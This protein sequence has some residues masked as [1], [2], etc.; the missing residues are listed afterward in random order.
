MILYCLLNEWFHEFAYNLHTILSSFGY[1]DEIFLF[2]SLLGSLQL[3]TFCWKGTPRVFSDVTRVEWASMDVHRPVQETFR[4]SINDFISSSL[5]FSVFTISVVSVILEREG[6][7]S[8]G[9]FASNKNNYAIQVLDMVLPL[10]TVHSF[11]VLVSITLYFSC[12]VLSILFGI[13]LLTFICH[14]YPP[15][16]FFTFSRVYL[17]VT[18]IFWLHLCFKA[19]IILTWMKLC[20]SRISSSFLLVL[21]HFL[22]LHWGEALMPD[23]Y[24]LHRICS[25]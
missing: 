2:F 19:Y 24:S 9:Y 23:Q 16:N 10:R 4:L 11:D 20:R 5:I 8:S 6:T 15:S 14:F 21:L 13:H 7:S 3:P 25:W 22:S 17:S 1:I 12:T 18:L